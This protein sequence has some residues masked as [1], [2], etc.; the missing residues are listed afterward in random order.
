MDA[1]EQDAAAVAAGIRGRKALELASETG[2][3]ALFM[4]AADVEDILQVP[5]TLDSVTDQGWLAIA[6]ALDHPDG[7]CAVLRDLWVKA[8]EEPD[9]G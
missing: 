6:V 1:A 4:L 8:G 7:S 9:R 5:G 2:A 3:M